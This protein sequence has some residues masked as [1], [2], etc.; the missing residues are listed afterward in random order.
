MSRSKTRPR[1]I[2]AWIF[3]FLGLALILTAFIVSGF[4]IYAFTTVRYQ[5]NTYEISDDF[6]AV[7]IVETSNLIAVYPSEDGVC[8]IHCDE[9]K[10]I[11]NKVSVQNGTL[12]V[13]RHDERPWYEK[14]VTVSF[15]SPKTT[16]YLPLKEYTALFL[17]TTSG[18]IKIG[19]ELTVSTAELYTTSGDITVTADT[20][21][22]LTARSTSG[23]IKLSEL[24][25]SAVSAASTSGKVDL[26]DI[27]ADTVRTSTTSGDVRITDVT[28]KNLKAASTSGKLDLTDVVTENTIEL[29]TTSG[30]VSL[31]RVDS[32]F[33]SIESTSGKVTGSLLSE[34]QFDVRSDTGDVTYPASL[35]G[36][37]CKIQTGSGDVRLEL[38]D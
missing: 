1:K 34:K 35:G 31:R 15:D 37:T 2:V 25:A 29:E 7:N 24:D 19:G 9:S 16:L 38:A 4:N 33:V 8:R 12:T 23:R 18:N 6:S 32:W 3:V 30:K 13:T 27:K 21:R 26:S 28:A 10:T 14:L 36:G 20:V 22:T 11:F 17:T 5:T